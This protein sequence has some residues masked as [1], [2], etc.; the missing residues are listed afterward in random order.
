MQPRNVHHYSGGDLFEIAATYA[1]H[2]AEAQAYIDGNKRT[3]IASA[4]VFLE[5]NGVDTTGIEPMEL[6]QSMIDISV[7]LLDREGLG[8]KLR[9][10]FG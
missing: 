5:C 4:L 10:L 8:E 2:I 7:H 6:Y 3:A 1:Y 9:E